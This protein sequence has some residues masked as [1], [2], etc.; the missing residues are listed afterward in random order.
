MIEFVVYGTP[1][2]QGNLTRNAH[3]AVYDKT[4]DHGPWRD[5][6]VHKIREAMD[7]EGI[8]EPEVGSIR[9]D[10]TFYFARPRSHYGSGRNASTIRPA[11]PG[12]YHRQKPD[13]D[14]LMRSLGDALTIARVIRDDC[15]IAEISTAKLWADRAY[16]YVALERL[17]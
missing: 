1:V 12:P 13:L 7:D 4:K 9:V 10:A 17:P 14:K 8:V 2:A 11:A 6:L 3:G 15:Q 16:V 5:S